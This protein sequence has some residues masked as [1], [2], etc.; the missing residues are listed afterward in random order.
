MSDT[1]IRVFPADPSFAPDQDARERALSLVAKLFPRAAEVKENVSDHPVFIDAGGNWGGVE[2]PRCGHDLGDWWRNAMNRA[3]ETKFS[4][5]HVKTPCCA[6]GT[7]L[8]ELHYGWPVGFGRYYI[9][10]LYPGRELDDSEL[11]ELGVALGTPVKQL[12]ARY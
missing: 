1:Y 6:L 2:C 5:L 7:A 8:N 10:V 12:W 4:D 9:G 3:W 11:Q